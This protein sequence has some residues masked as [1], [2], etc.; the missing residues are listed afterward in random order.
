MFAPP[1]VRIGID[2]Q[3]PKVYNMVR[4]IIAIGLHNLTNEKETIMF[5]RVAINAAIAVFTISSLIYGE[6]PEVLWNDQCPCSFA[7]SPEK[8]KSLKKEISDWPPGHIHTQLEWPP[9]EYLSDPNQ[10]WQKKIQFAKKILTEIFK[11]DILPLNSIEKKFMLSKVRFHKDYPRRDVLV[12][13]C[14]KGK[15]IIKVMYTGSSL[16]VTARL[17]SGKN[18]EI[19][20]L[21]EDI[22]Q[23]RILPYKWESPCYY[24]HKDNQENTILDTRGYWIAKDYLK[25]DSKGNLIGA[26]D[27][28]PITKRT[29]PPYGPVGV[30]P[31]KYKKVDFI[32][33]GKFACFSI[34]GGTYIKPGPRT[35]IPEKEKKK[36]EI[37]RRPASRG[38]GSRK[39]DDPNEYYTGTP[40]D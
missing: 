5:M 34:I 4:C 13:R 40:S 33:G 19:K 20:Q 9:G 17:V 22:F 7:D 26:D 2:L 36:P 35:V 12:F 8:A 29:K 37:R 24:I 3:A 16:N 6:E 27:H 38:K 15:Y 21:S 25:P 10:V 30:G 23:D 32:R 39:Y 18:I 14:K 1:I 28:L 31:Y 11:P